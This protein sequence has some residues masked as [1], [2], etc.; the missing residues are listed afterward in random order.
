[1]VR[2]RS[3]FFWGHTASIMWLLAEVNRDHDKR[4]TPYTPDTFN[5][6]RQKAKS[7]LPKVK[8][9][10]LKN[11]VPAIAELAKQRTPMPRGEELKAMI[12]RSKRRSSP[13][14][15]QR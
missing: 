11:I 4:S 2:G 14:T 6:Y 15:E 12:E 1:M 5:P 8:M 7:E 9:K 13:G 10:D 3:E